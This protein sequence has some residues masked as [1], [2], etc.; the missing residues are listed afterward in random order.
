MDHVIGAAHG[1][2]VLFIPAEKRWSAFNASGAVIIPT[3]GHSSVYD[4]HSQLIF[5]HGGYRLFAR[6]QFLPLS[7][8]LNAYN[9][10]TRHWYVTLK[11]VTVVLWK[12]CTVMVC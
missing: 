8:E 12:V 3:Y 4:P 9:P 6:E 11:K 10:L 1:T 5:V 7:S 2:S